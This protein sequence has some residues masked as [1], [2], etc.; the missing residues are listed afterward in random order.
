MLGKFAAVVGPAMLGSV[1]LLTG[2]IRYGVVSL[3][4]LFIAGGWLLTRVNIAEGEQDR[5]V[6]S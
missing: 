1:A 6:R 3:L 5:P 4:I 2:N